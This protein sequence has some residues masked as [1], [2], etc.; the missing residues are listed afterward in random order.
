MPRREHP[1]SIATF[2]EGEATNYPGIAA[3]G[4][5]GSQ[6]LAGVSRRHPHNREI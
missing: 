2:I 1:D 4:L 6:R 3:S 5:A